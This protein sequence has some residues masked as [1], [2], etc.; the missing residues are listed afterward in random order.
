MSSAQKREWWQRNLDRYFYML[1]GKHGR[2]RDSYE[3]QQEIANGAAEL[4]KEIDAFAEKFQQDVEGYT[5]RLKNSLSE[6]SPLWTP[7]PTWMN[8]KKKKRPIERLEKDRKIIEGRIVRG[9]LVP[10]GGRVHMTMEE[11]LA[12][13]KEKRNMSRARATQIPNRETRLVRR[14]QKNESKE[15]IPKVAGR[16]GIT[17]PANREAFLSEWEMVGKRLGRVKLGGEGITA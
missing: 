10:G 2:I 3:L 13:I 8:W 6:S 15:W 4:R 1:E 5:E 9:G 12:K 14:D 17:R 16:L 7:L 11:K